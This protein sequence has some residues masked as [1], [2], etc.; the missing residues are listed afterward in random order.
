MFIMCRRRQRRRERH[1]KWLISI[2]RPRPTS[3]ADGSQDPFQDPRSPPTPPMR[4][5]EPNWPRPPH[6]YNPGNGLGLTAIGL[7]ITTNDAYTPSLAQSSPSIY[8]PSLPPANDELIEEVEPQPQRYSDSSV[9]PPRPR[10]SHLRDPP[11]TAQLVTPPSSVSSHSPVSEYTGPF[12]FKTPDGEPSTGPIQ[13][14]DIIQRRT[15]LDVRPRSQ[16]SVA[17]KMTNLRG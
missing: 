13:L 9:A 3:M 10:R 4:A 7:A 17:Q 8:P 14:N 2:N 5:V 15:L 16:D 11:S 12:S 1:R 6:Q